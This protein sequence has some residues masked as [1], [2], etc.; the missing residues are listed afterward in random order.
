MAQ[1]HSVLFQDIDLTLWRHELTSGSS[2]WVRGPSCSACAEH[3]VLIQRLNVY[4]LCIA[5]NASHTV[6]KLKIAARM[7]RF[8]AL[9]DVWDR[10]IGPAVHSLLKVWR[11]VLFFPWNSKNVRKAVQDIKKNTT[12]QNLP[13]RL[14]KYNQTAKRLVWSPFLSL[15]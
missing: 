15:N 3:H 1:K 11:F 10:H 4:I 7:K 14:N 13:K 5:L 9:G 12:R 6:K 2:C 8:K